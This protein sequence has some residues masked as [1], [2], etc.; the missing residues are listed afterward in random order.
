MVQSHIHEAGQLKELMMRMSDRLFSSAPEDV[1]TEH[2]ASL[3]NKWEDNF[4]VVIRR[5]RVLKE[6]ED[7]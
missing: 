7:E 1:P 3:R 6:R 5:L 4:D 2:F